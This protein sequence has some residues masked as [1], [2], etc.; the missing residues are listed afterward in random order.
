M[1]YRKQHLDW[2]SIGSYKRCP[3]TLQTEERDEVAPR[4]VGNTT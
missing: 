2:L 4:R 1:S 3:V